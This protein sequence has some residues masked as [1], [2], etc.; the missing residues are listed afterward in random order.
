MNLL[1]YIS[2]AYHFVNKPN[3]L[4]MLKEV[5]IDAWTQKANDTNCK[6]CVIARAIMLHGSV[7]NVLK[8]RPAGLLIE[9]NVVKVSF[10]MLFVVILS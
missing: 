3:E 1:L 8:S 9:A 5:L 2:H 7:G 4:I 6:P 10:L